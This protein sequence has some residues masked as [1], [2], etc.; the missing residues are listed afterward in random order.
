MEPSRLPEYRNPH[1]LGGLGIRRT[2]L[3][4][5]SFLRIWLGRL[6]FLES[7][8]DIK[9]NYPGHN[10]LLIVERARC[11][12]IEK[13]ESR[14]SR[15]S[16]SYTHRAYFVLFIPYFAEA[17]RLCSAV[18]LP[19]LTKLG[20]LPL[21]P[22]C[23]MSF[24]APTHV[25]SLGGPCVVEGLVDWAQSRR[26]RS[27]TGE[28]LRATNRQIRPHPVMPAHGRASMNKLICSLRKRAGR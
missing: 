6:F 5:L 8:R 16:C 3:Y 11:E 25:P 28:E 14:Q 21:V 7:C 9:L 13:L 15:C 10:I 4:D 26:S 23:S 19:L 18:I 2:E 27:V 17:S 12:P 22:K 1:A 24:A 20:L